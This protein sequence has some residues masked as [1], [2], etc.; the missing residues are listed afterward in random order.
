VD[1]FF[2]KHGVD[3]MLTFNNTIKLHSCNTLSIYFCDTWWYRWHYL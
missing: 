2:L 3:A 1:V